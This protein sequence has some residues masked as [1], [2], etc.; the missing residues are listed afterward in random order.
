MDAGG[1]QAGGWS[2]LT[3]GEA[4]CLGRHHRPEPFLLGFFE[5]SSGP[6]QPGGDLLVAQHPLLEGFGGVH[7]P[8]GENRSSGGLPPS[9]WW[10]RLEPR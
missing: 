10:V 8:S 7:F 5:A 1:A 9:C 3:E 2:N 4:G 6:F